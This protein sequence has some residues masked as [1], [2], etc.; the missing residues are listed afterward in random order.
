M[1]NSNP[2]QRDAIERD[3]NHLLV[4]CSADELR[5]LDLLLARLELGRRRYGHLDL[6]RVREWDREEAEELLDARIYQA[7]AILTRR[8]LIADAATL[9]RKNTG[10]DG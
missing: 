3:I 9:E 8:D 10:F 6:A 4:A 1:S 5:V 7:C 2:E